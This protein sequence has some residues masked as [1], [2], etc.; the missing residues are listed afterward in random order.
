MSYADFHRI[1][2]QTFSFPDFYGTNMDAWIDCMSQLDDFES[3]MSQFTVKSNQLVVLELTGTAEFARRCPDIYNDLIDYT[4]S[5]N[6]RRVLSGYNPILALL[7][8]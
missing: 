5:V 1:F 4:T 2:K 6:Q 8:R 7:F 3:G